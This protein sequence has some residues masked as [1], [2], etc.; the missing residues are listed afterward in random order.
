MTHMAK[1]GILAG[2]GDAPKSVIAACR[3]SGRPFYVF[4]LQ[5][6]ADAD[7]PTLTPDCEGLGLGAF[8]HLKKRCHELSIE[9]IVMIGSVRRPSVAELKPDWLGVKVM[10]RIGLSSLGDDGLLRALGQAIEQ[11]CGVRVVGA[12]EVTG[13]ILTPSGILG[14]VQPDDQ[15]RADVARGIEVAS[16]LGALDVGQ[17]VIVQGG[18]VLG[19]EAIE[20]TDALIA[21][22]GSLARAGG[23]GVL[24]KLAKPQQDSR[25]DLPT[26]GARTIESL[27]AAGF[28]GV[29]VE[30]GRSLLLGQSQT[31]AAADQAGLFIWGL[32][33]S[34]DSEG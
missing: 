3:A 22:T 2:G 25:Y 34:E 11:E 31:I 26:I 6:Q 28:S 12:H 16:T 19:V 29:A 30:A 5:G 8:G 23:G 4:C 9:E 33:V 18:L 20:G 24:V 21:R 1:L 10:A 17:S 7:L 14:R 15:A 27:A 32:Q 13:G